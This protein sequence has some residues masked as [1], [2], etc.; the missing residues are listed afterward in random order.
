MI[1]CRFHRPIVLT[2][3][4]LNMVG[5]IKGKSHLAK[6]IG[7]DV[8]GRAIHMYSVGIIYYEGSFIK[9]TWS[10]WRLEGRGEDEN[11]GKHI[12]TAKKLISLTSFVV[13]IELVSK[14]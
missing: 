8:C 11:Q 5:I 13:K 9:V 10:I 12:R 3:S 1:D 7:W 4:K 14:K 6:M 2:K